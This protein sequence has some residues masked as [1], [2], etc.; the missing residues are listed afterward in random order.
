MKVN[1]SSR[2]MMPD[3]NAWSSMGTIDIAKDDKI[4]EYM[5]KPQKFVR[6][7]RRSE[8]QNIFLSKTLDVDQ[9]P[10]QVNASRKTIVRLNQAFKFG[11]RANSRPHNP[12]VV[13]PGRYSMNQLENIEKFKQTQVA[14]DA[15]NL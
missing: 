6:L 10:K 7:K 3:Y 12:L 4:N 15:N 13:K 14:V 1:H 9:E 8:N 2:L 11:T 5:N